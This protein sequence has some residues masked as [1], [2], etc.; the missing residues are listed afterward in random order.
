MTV[1]QTPAAITVDAEVL[2]GTLTVI[3]SDRND[4]VVDIRPSDASKKADV[5]AAE[6]IKVD[7]TDGVLTVNTPKNWRNHSPFSG[8]P[9]VEVRIEVPTGSAL[10]AV[11][12]VGHLLG[13]G[14][15]G[16]VDMEIASGDIIVERPLGSVTAKAA[17]GDIRIVEAARGVMQLET[18]VGE[19]EV[20]IRPGSAVRVETNTP[21]GSVHN[22]LSSVAPSETGDS[23][24]VFAR[25]SFGNIIIGHAAAV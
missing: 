22:Q 24:Q 17:Q 13:L 3:A 2:S 8:T 23:V 12:G 6:Q 25:N 14:A 9:T 18:S 10:K 1:F 19:L 7:F 11:G 20:G 16:V 4:T 15:L 5:R 21:H